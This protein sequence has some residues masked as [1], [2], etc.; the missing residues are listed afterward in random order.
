M[1]H[2]DSVTASGKWPP[3]WRSFFISWF[4]LQVIRLALL[5]FQPQVVNKH[6][7]VM[8]D[9]KMAVAYINKQGGTGLKRLFTLAKSILLWCCMM[10]T[11]I[12][13]QHI[14][15]RLNVKADLLSHKSQVIGSDWSLNP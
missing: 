5:V 13:F 10:R 1:P 2:S 7:L 3:Q 11:R 15:G 9:I 14:A 6:V 4:E 8:C 12:F